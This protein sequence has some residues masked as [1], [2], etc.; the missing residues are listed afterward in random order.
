MHRFGQP[1][2]LLPRQKTER[3]SRHRGGAARGLDCGLR[4]GKCQPSVIEKSPASRR[5]FD[6]ARAAYQQL[7]ADLDLK[8]SYLPT[9]RRLCGVQLLLRRNREAPSLR[10]CDK[11]PKVPEFHNEKTH[12]CLACSQTYEVFLRAARLTYVLFKG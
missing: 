12:A 2:H 7:N 11:V 6:P 3:E 9:E 5:Q 4:L 1:I 10:D 8:I